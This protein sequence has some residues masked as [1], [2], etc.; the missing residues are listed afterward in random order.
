MNS[1]ELFRDI[2]NWEGFVSMLENLNKKEKGDGF[3]E[4]T[5]PYFITTKIKFLA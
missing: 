1:K 5:K 3:G 4:F 2:E